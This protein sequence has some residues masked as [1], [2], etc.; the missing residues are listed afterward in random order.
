MRKP[1]RRRGEVDSFSLHESWV[2]IILGRC[3]PVCGGG[4]SGGISLP[5]SLTLGLIFNFSFDASSTLHLWDRNPLFA[6]DGLWWLHHSQI[7]A[8]IQ[9]SG[10]KP[11]V[12]TYELTDPGVSWFFSLC[13]SAV[14]KRRERRSFPDRSHHA[15]IS[16]ENVLVIFILKWSSLSV[17]SLTTIF[18]WVGSIYLSNAQRWDTGLCNVTSNLLGIDRYHIAIQGTCLSK[19]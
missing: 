10:Y 8:K 19:L 16:F 18:K 17:S 4:R 12:G 15:V 2:Y 6:L 14:M 1:R 3:A 7:Q 9:F 5:T 13:R 11:P